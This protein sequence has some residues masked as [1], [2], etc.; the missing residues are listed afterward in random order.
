MCGCIHML[1]AERHQRFISKKTE[2]NH[3]TSA[4]II[5]N[6]TPKSK[7]SGPGRHARNTHLVGE[8]KGI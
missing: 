6:Q 5:G 7:L 1:R 3:I 8:T 4:T 2:T